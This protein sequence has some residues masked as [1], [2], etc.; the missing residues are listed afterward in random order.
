M[1]SPPYRFGQGF[2]APLGGLVV[3]DRERDALDAGQ[4]EFRGLRVDE[5][6]PMPW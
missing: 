3:D 2:T 4:A 1:P 5:L 6:E